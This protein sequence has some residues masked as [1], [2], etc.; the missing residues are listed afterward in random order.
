MSCYAVSMRCPVLTQAIVLCDC[1]RREATWVFQ[2]AA[3]S[4]GGSREGRGRGRGGRRG[5]V[6]ARRR[7]SSE[8][9]GRRA[10]GRCAEARRERETAG[11]GP[12]SAL[13]AAAYAPLVPGSA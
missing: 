7:L 1:A 3:A 2:V 13:V 4:G 12:R 5:G 8:R 6:E 10:A 9:R 11:V